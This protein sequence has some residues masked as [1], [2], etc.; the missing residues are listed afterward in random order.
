MFAR[1]KRVG[2]YAYLQ[3]VRT[4]RHGGPP[5]QRVLA[6]L[7]RVEHLQSCGELDGL[8]R[9]LSQYSPQALA[10]VCG[11]TQPTT[12]TWKLGPVRM[13]ERLWQ[14]L[15]LGE[16]LNGLL[17]GRQFGFGV[18]RAIFVTVLHRL[19]VS[20]SDR[21]AERWRQGYVSQADKYP[22]VD[23]DM[24]AAGK[25][26]LRFL[27]GLKKKGQLPGWSKNDEVTTAMFHFY[28]H[29]PDRV[30]IDDFMKQGD[31]SI[32]HYTVARASK[33]SPWR[34]QKAWRTDRNDHTIQEFPVH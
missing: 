31:S 8:L 29:Y 17:A 24:E 32:Y 26:A 30:T 18:E 13:F 1:I 19:C 14:R 3:L 10:L 7:G 22:I 9:S 27:K 34:L 11:Q 12:R 5:R 25:S 28:I 15:G 33:D 16:I 20:G 2:A 6:T 4:E 21:Q 23:E